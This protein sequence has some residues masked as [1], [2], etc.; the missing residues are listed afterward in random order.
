MVYFTDIKETRHYIENHKKEFSWSEV[1]KTIYKSLKNIRKKHGKYEIER[2]GYYILMELK[3][4]TLYVLNAKKRRWNA[5]N[6]A[7]N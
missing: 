1:L 3:D 7:Q 6:V 2:N 4:K 5:Q